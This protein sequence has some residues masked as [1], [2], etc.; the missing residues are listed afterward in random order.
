[1]DSAYRTG[2]LWLLENKIDTFLAKSGSVYATLN[3]YYRSSKLFLLKEIF[4]IKVKKFCSRDAIQRDC[5]PH[6]Q[7][8]YV[9]YYYHNI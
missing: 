8:I 9:K 3:Y 7:T 5:S 6:T 2:Y 1:M 4:V